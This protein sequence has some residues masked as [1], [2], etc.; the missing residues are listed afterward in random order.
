MTLQRAFA[1]PAERHLPGATA[2]PAGGPVAV[3]AAVARATFEPAQ[4][5]ASETYLFGFD[6]LAGGFF[7]EAH[8]VWEPVWMR[9]L[10]NS[11]ERAVAQALIQCANAGLKHAMGRR[12]ATMR[13]LRIAAALFDEAS[14]GPTVMGL[15]AALAAAAM[16]G[17]GSAGPGTDA[18]AGIA[19]CRALQPLCIILQ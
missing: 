8:E 12:G 7:W 2:G 19:G 3:A 14:A 16:R 18:A 17:L 13:L 11:R 15:D 1:L 9:C 4:W 10:P 6:L 5:S